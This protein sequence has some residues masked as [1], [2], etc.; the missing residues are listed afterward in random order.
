MIKKNLLVLVAV[1]GFAI[2][3]NAGVVFRTQQSLC[4][5]NEQ[6]IL[7]SNGTVQ[8]WT[9]STLQYSGTYTVEGNIIIMSVEGG[10]FRA[11][12]EM[13]DSKTKV[14]NLTFNGTKYLPCNQ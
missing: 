3:V 1:I 13:N 6:I 11:K 9:N 10:Q 7:K 8:I 14:W 5:G 4:S 12:A 2:S